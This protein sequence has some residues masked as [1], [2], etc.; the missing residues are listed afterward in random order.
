MRVPQLCWAVCRLLTKKGN[1]GFGKA[2]DRAMATGPL[3]ILGAP[4]GRQCSWGMG[5][6]NAW[7]RVMNSGA[8]RTSWPP[9]N[10]LQHELLFT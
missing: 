8:S 2:S 10:H 3:N 5:D 9:R 4:N 6:P 7:L 1:S